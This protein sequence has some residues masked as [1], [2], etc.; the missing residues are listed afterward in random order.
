M[1]RLNAQRD[2][3]AALWT[4]VGLGT[5]LATTGFTW[6]ASKTQ[7]KSFQKHPRDGGRAT[8]IRCFTLFTGTSR[9]MAMRPMKPPRRWRRRSRSVWSNDPDVRDYH[10]AAVLLLVRTYGDPLLREMVD[11]FEGGNCSLFYS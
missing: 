5:H 2:P 6:L 10:L 9:D 3:R 11:G 8:K 7:R 4:R 1:V